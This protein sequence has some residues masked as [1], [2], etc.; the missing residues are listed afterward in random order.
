MLLDLVMARSR[1]FGPSLAR[2]AR[3]RTAHLSQSSGSCRALKLLPYVGNPTVYASGI[4]CGLLRLARRRCPLPL[5]GEAQVCGI[6]F[7]R[8]ATDHAPA[9]VACISTSEGGLL[10]MGDYSM[11]SLLYAYDAPPPAETLITDASYGAYDT[12]SARVLS[13]FD[14]IFDDAPVLFPTATAGRG[15]KKRFI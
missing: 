5:H 10:Y 1:V 8:A 2:R 9:R 14:R 13:E 11:E 15:P 12:S 6:T 4:V 3:R 7:E